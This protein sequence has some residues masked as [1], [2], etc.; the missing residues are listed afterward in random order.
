MLCP[1]SPAFPCCCLERS[2]GF[3]R[4]LTQ[5]TNSCLGILGWVP[6]STL[7]EVFYETLYLGWFSTMKTNS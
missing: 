1:R 2:M 4:N 3:K 5:K 7:W 6:A